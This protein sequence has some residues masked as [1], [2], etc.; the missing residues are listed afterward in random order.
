MVTL[1]SGVAAVIGVVVGALVA[2]VLT[3]GAGSR[4]VA[5]A[6][7]AQAQQL[8]AA[9]ARLDE[10][11]VRLADLSGRLRVRE[12]DIERLQIRVSGLAA[13][14]ARLEGDLAAAVDRNALLRTAEE[15]LRDAF[16]SLASEALQQNS[17]SVLR[18]ARATL[19]EMQTRAVADLDKRQQSISEV[20]KP[21]VETL[22][23]VDAKLG[24]VEMDRATTTAKLDEQIRTLGAGL[25]VLN[26]QTGD[27]V[28][29]LRQPHVRG[30]WGELQL[31]R[32][33]ELAGML[34]HCDFFEQHTATSADGRFRPDLIVRLPGA[35]QIVVDAKAPLAAY[36]ESID[37]PDDQ[38]RAARLADHARQV[39]EHMTKL[40][41]KA[42]WNQFG[43]T[44]EF[45]VMFLPGEAFFSA[46][47]QHD[48]S[49][50]EFG[51]AERVVPASPTTLIAL[52]KAVAYGWR[53]ERIAENAEQISVLGRDLYN[54][55]LAMASHFDEV[56]RGLERAVDAYNKSV[57]SL[58]TRVLPAARKFKE[59]GAAPPGADI[60]EL[61]AVQTSPRTLQSPDLAPLLDIVEAETLD[62]L[63]LPPDAALTSRG[64][65][66]GQW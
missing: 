49:L 35:K 62:S 54:R 57:A 3:R 33:V 40:A 59:L 32:V 16:R 61:K 41:S 28:K 7:G 23:Q 30:H 39:R 11:A 1:S 4:R 2:W 63:T 48:S 26:G 17:E 58:E 8:G 9:E 27:L 31:K 5:E 55:V 21:L 19:G 24:Q 44:P 46:A 20:V 51:A 37:A 22:H 18:L 15:T 66:S 25:T 52:L 12:Q 65:D 56:R 6:R 50:I 10:T 47:L 42:Y 43:A 45:V 60:D 29:A 36:L 38:T 53:Q 14:K 13:E 34:E 64:D